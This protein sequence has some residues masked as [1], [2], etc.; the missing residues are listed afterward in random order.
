MLSCGPSLGDL[1]DVQIR[2]LAKG[3]VVVAIKQAYL[4]CPDIVD[5]HLVNGVNFKRYDYRGSKAKVIGHGVD[6]KMGK[7]DIWFKNHD[8]KKHG[9]IP[10]GWNSSLRKSVA[11]NKNYDDYLLH[12]CPS[13][14]SGPGIV[15]T[16]GYYLGIH[17]GV[18]KLILTGFDLGLPGKKGVEHFYGKNSSVPL[19]GNK[20]NESLNSRLKIA[21]GE[22][23]LLLD[24]VRYM[25]DFLIFHSGRE[26]N[27]NNSGSSRL[28][29]GEPELIRDTSYDF[30]EWLLSHEVN[31]YLLSNRSEADQRIPRITYDEILKN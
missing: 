30:Y 10:E 8:T 2:E 16:L 31:L 29:V 23:S 5:Y 24:Y 28:P 12:I 11:I 18:S 21:L 3:R 9:N 14:P 19:S 7:R 22:K 17:L 13:R 27:R 26:L 4:R 15:Y 20:T 25:R 6:P 1:R